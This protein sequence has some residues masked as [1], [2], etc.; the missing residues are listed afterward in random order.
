MKTFKDLI[1][2]TIKEANHKKLIPY[3]DTG[4]LELVFTDGTKVV[5]MGYYDEE[6][7][8]S[9]ESEGEYSTR[10]GMTNE[11]DGLL[12]NIE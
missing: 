12:E 3:D 4:Y 8:G 9:G 6:Y 2:K 5:I 10:I 1:G 7:K 11:F